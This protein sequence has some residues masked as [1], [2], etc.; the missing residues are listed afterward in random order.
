MKMSTVGNRVRTGALLTLSMLVL[1]ILVMTHATPALSQSTATLMV[2]NLGQPSSA[3]RTTIVGD[4][5][6]A[7]SFCTGSVAATLAKVRIYTLS[8]SAEGNPHGYTD[9]PAPVVTI[10]STDPSGKPGPALHTLTSPLIDGSMDTAEDFTSSGYE[11]AANT[12]YSVVIRRPSGTGHIAFLDTEFSPEDTE[13]QLGWTIGDQYMWNSGWGWTDQHRKGHI[14]KMAVYAS[15]GLP[16]IS[17]PAFTDCG[18]TISSYQFSVDENAPEDTVVDIAAA[19]DADGDSLTYSVSGTGAAK[20]NNV[21][22]LNARTGEITVKSGASI[23]YES[24]DKSYSVTVSVTD[25]EDAT[26][27]AESPPTIDATTSVSIEVINIDEPGTA[28]LSTTAPKVG[29]EL[30][31]SVSDPDDD[32]L[33]IYTVQWARAANADAPFIDIP[34]N[35]A[36]MANPSYT[37]TAA[38]QSKYLKVT[39]FY[40]ERQCGEVSSFDDRCRREATKTLTTLVANAEGLI[41]QSQRVNRPATG[42]PLIVGAPPPG[43]QSG[44]AGW[45]F[46]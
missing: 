25:G 34:I 37:P 24:S 36:D 42:E 38:D 10:R 9:R 27:A 4:Q 8:N 45:G 6:Y 7:Q 5:E 46:G 18:D 31:V 20:F 2:S 35:P 12:T 22:N 19:G 15:G 16:P 3:L 26:G 14:M 32:T 28:T 41:T 1:L 44:S 11:L 33:L 29:S 40:V 17:T 30:T 21:F 13:T 23:D 39:V 43:Y